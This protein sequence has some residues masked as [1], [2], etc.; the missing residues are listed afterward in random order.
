MSG[1]ASSAVRSNA[2]RAPRR[3]SATPPRLLVAPPR[4]RRGV[5]VVGG[6]ERWRGVA[7]G[8]HCGKRS[9]YNAGVGL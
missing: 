3:L 2:R 8:G 1:V 9:V 6:V 7:T 5:R 4:A